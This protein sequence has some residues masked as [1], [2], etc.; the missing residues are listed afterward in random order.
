MV[1]IRAG[2]VLG[3]EFF[4]VLDMAI[5]HQL[6]RLHGVL[7]S[8]YFEY[9]VLLIS[10]VFRHEVALSAEVVVQRCAD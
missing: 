4:L 5:V 6:L 10:G 1:G 8:N 7:F 3:V 9:A 2:V